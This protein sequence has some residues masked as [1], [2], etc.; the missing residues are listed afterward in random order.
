MGTAIIKNNSIAIVINEVMF[1]PAEAGFNSKNALAPTLVNQIV[2]NYSISRIVASVSDVG[3]VVLIHFVFLN[4][5]RRCVNYK[6]SL[7]IVA[8]NF[9]V[10]DFDVS[11]VAASDASFPIIANMMIF[12]HLGVV[13]LSFKCNAVFEILL[14]PIIPNNSIRPQVVLSVY[15]DTEFSVFCDFVHHNVGVGAD[16]L[17]SM[18][19]FIYF[20]ELNLS[21]ITSI[22]LNTRP[23]N[24]VDSAPEDLGFG[25]YS[26]AVNTHKLTIKEVTILNY[27]SVLSFG[28]EVDGSL[29]VVRESAV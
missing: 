21:L 3:L 8:E 26:L 25:V 1:D 23:L 10:Y 12:L 9:V 16:G 20:A 4:I 7:A 11:I 22:N 19:V 2:Q 17:D 29:F 6:N 24:V 5:G 15:V 18:L 13:F 14:H 28:D 27:H